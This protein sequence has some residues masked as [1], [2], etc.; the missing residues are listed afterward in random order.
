[1]RKDLTEHITNP[2][3]EKKGVYDLRS[4]CPD[5]VWLVMTVVCRLATRTVSTQLVTDAWL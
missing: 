2:P 1:M 4:F 3:I 5:W